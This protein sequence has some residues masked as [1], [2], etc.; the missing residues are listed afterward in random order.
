MTACDIGRE[1]IHAFLDD[2]F[3]AP[4]PESLSHHLETCPGCRELYE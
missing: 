3:D 1:R 2:T 4:P